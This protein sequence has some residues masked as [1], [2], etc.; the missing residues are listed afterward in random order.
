MHT[1]LLFVLTNACLAWGCASGAEPAGSNSVDAGSTQPLH[2]RVS[3]HYAQN[4]DVK[5]H[6]VALG[7]GPLV[8]MIHGFPDFW[9][10]WREQMTALAPN[11]RV[12]AMDN[13]GYNRSDQPEGVDAYAT[14]NLVGDVAAVINAEDAG[15]AVVVGHDWGG[16]IAWNVAMFEPELVSNLI[17]LNLPHPNGLGREIA[18]NPTQRANSSYAFEFQKPNA[19]DALSAEGLA[20][21]VRDPAAKMHYLTAFERSSF[22]GMLNYYKAN[23]PNP[24]ALP[25]DA[26]DAQPPQLPKVQAPV[27]VMHGLDDQA[28]LPG[29]HDGTWQWVEQDLTLVTVPGAGHFV[30]H[31][32]SNFVTQN[33]LAWLE[34]RVPNDAKP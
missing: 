31:D 19:H 26:E 25:S 20:R 3:H 32:A 12:V 23:Y 17:V 15:P 6:Y 11:Y 29:G 5:I 30:Q 9:Y 34:Q 13:R 7:N 4:G 28:L 1:R 33:I 16:F 27:L 8:V 18:N 24:E 22:E 14:P 21:W 10:T 2:E